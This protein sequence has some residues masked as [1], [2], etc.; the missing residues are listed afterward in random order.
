MQDHPIIR[1]VIIGVLVLIVGALATA[2]KALFVGPRGK[3]GDTA[4]V[5]AL[6]VRVGLSIGLFVLLMVLYA[7]GIIEPRGG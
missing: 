4:G 5:K 1:Y 7:L 2:F 3:P 6:T